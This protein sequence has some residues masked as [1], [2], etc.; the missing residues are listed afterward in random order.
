MNNP[1]L[2]WEAFYQEL[3]SW[4]SVSEL[5]QILRAT[6]PEEVLALLRAARR[7]DLL[8]DPDE[9]SKRVSEIIDILETHKRWEQRTKDVGAISRLFVAVGAVMTVIWA[10]WDKFGAWL[11]K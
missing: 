1:Q 4:C 9:V 8:G 3:V 7:L 11:S 6:K 10:F 2:Q 5:R